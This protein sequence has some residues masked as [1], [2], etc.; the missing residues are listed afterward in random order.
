MLKLIRGWLRAGVLEDG[1]VTATVSGT[2][3]GSPISPLLANVALH[4]LDEAW[5]GTATRL[6]VLVRYA[7]DFVVVCPTQAR[8]EQARG[9]AGEVLG[10]DSGCNCTPTRPGSSA[11][12]GAGTALTSSGSTT[13]WWSPGGGEAVST[14]TRWPS[15]RAMRSI[16]AKIREC[17]GP[18][19]RRLDIWL[20][21]A[22][23]N[24]RAT[25]LGNYFR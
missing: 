20:V 14:C 19:T 25:G 17:T 9:L 8:A 13:R 5:Q 18:P 3:Q 7:D 11:S 6:G 16:R 15:D 23:I 4:V 22:E 10:P 12:P 24:R 21:V 2:P 1:S